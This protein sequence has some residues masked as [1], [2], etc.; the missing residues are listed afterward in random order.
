MQRDPIGLKGDLNVYEYCGSRPMH[1]VDPLGLWYYETDV[2]DTPTHVYIHHYKVTKRPFWNKEV[3]YSHTIT[4]T[5]ICV[6]N[7]KHFDFSGSDNDI[8]EWLDGK[9]KADGDHQGTGIEEASKAFDESNRRILNKAG[10]VGKLFD[11]TTP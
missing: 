8:N 7:P 2:I 6:F 9:H 11:K 5:K 1:F 4:I 10:K 3:V